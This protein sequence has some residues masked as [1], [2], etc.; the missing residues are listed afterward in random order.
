MEYLVLGLVGLGIYTGGLVLGVLAFVRM[1]RYRKALIEQQV[2]I[3]AL[4]AALAG[5]GVP[6]PAHDAATEPPPLPPFMRPREIAAAASSAH[7]RQATPRPPA[8]PP[9]EPIFPVAIAPG[10]RLPKTPV[11]VAPVVAAA[12]AEGM[13]PAAPDKSID[14]ALWATWAFG[15]AVASGI[16]AFLNNAYN[17]GY[18]NQASQLLLGY[19]MAAGLLGGSEVLRRRAITHPPTDIQARHTPKILAAVGLVCAYGITFVGYYRLGLLP[20]PAA[21]GLMGVFSL[22]A[23]AVSLWHGRLTAWLG[24]VAGFGAPVLIGSSDTP[25]TALFAYLFAICAGA[26]ALSHHKRWYG[27]GGAASVAALAWAA[28][29]TYS[30]FSPS[31]VSAASGF[32]VAIALLGAAFAWNDSQ[33]AARIPLPKTR[34][35]WIGM[36]TILG[37]GA[38]LTFLFANAHG[39]GAP[40][41]FA[42]IGLTAV[43]CGIAAAR[44]GFAPAPL[45]MGALGAAALA[46]WPEIDT[47][48]AART[49][50]GFAGA[51]GFAASVGGWAM[52]ARNPAP[53]AGALVAAV[54]PAATLFIAHARLG[55]AIDQPLGWGLAA[56]ALA[57]FNAVALD[58]IAQAVG[59]ASKAPLATGAFA[60]AAAACAVMAGFFA[61]DQVRLAAGVAVLIISLAWLDKRLTLPPARI[62]AIFVAVVTVALLSPVALMRAPVETAPILN[63]LAPTFI[64]AIASVWISARL[65]ATGPAGYLGQVTVVLRI[66]LIAL[67]LAFLWAEI[68]HLTNGG[69]MA[70]PYTS[71]LEAGAHTSTW[72]I[73][74]LF[75][76]W[77]FGAQDRPLLHW[78]ERLTFGAALI[79]FA[80][81][82]LILLAPWW[83]TAPGKVTGPP[84]F[85]TLLIAYAAPAALFAGYA[86]LRSRMGSAFVAQISGCAAV[87]AAVAW[88]L[89]A[90]RHGFHPTDAASATIV[91]F[92]HAAYSFVLAISAALV[93]AVAYFR[94]APTLRYVSA[95]LAVAAFAKALVVDAPLI[96]G[97]A[98]YAAYALLAAAAAATFIGFQRYIFPRGP[99]HAAAAAQTGSSND[100]TLLPPRP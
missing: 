63:T 13:A 48:S 81:A 44:A 80:L 17:Q 61:L 59:G 51:L 75:A 24:I 20:P 41:V 69:A 25:A 8:R 16:I 73:I 84:L 47:S 53:G 29:W 77:R 78:T 14:V 87:V 32:L 70:A 72:M 28:W 96:D 74:A 49:Y 71:L 9:A 35:A 99:A 55:A 21:I 100:A 88:A 23:S 6:L 86:A 46:F 56:L 27:V 52:M 65:F 10:V 83:G 85:N 12:P 43:L 19:V 4:E 95:A 18:F 15:A 66:T 82:G 91:P 54:V 92:E 34:A 42:L 39:F 40:A 57:A 64:I 67:G 89:L 11:P 98:K 93:L 1:E 22:A 60:L 45:L 38:A 7:I 94:Q 90:M 5:R 37:A 3:D 33:V 2:R 68:R 62:A 58:R 31:G 79:H 26:F 97:L 50:S 76:A 36:A 30:W